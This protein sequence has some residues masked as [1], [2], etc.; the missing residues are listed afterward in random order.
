VTGQLADRVAVITGAGRG[1]G[2]AIAEAFAAEG[3]IVVVSDIDE[4]AAK[5]VAATLSRA[6]AVA[7]DVRDEA[8]VQALI[9]GT[10]ERH[11]RV[12]VSVANA[13]IAIVKPLAETSLA[14]W[15]A[16]TS[17]NLDGVFLT[18]RESALAMA[19]AGGGS[20]VV[21]GSI[22]ALRGSPLIG[23][24]AATKA[25]VVNLTK[26]AATEFRA[27]GV[28]VNALLPTFIGTDLVNENIPTFSAALGGDFIP[29][30]EQKQVRMGEVGDITPLAV[31]LASDSSKFTT[32]S[33]FVVDNGWTASLL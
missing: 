27:H 15:R 5:E 26:T 12:D 20:I 1:I 24:Y 21:L 11:G 33:D 8:A 25:A 22:T 7:C 19:A 16:V 17:V 9:R 30:I 32:G 4:G 28:R 23:S 29:L 31:Y 10:V 3:A 14:E 2:R 6:E 13:G 18:V